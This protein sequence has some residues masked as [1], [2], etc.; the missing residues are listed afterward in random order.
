MTTPKQC[1][2]LDEIEGYGRERLKLRMMEE[3]G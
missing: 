2:K 1:H 3:S